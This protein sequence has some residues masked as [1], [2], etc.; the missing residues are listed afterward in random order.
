MG[1]PLEQQKYH[2]MRDRARRRR[3]GRREGGG[4]RDEDDKIS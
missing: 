2:E 1:L 4:E 3:R